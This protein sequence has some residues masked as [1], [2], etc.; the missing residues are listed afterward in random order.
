MSADNAKGVKK[1]VSPKKEAPKKA[2]YVMAKGCSLTSKKGVLKPGQE[3]KAEYWPEQKT[4]D[5]WLKDGYI[6]KG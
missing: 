3:V 2:A 5:K 6:V 4:F 1:E